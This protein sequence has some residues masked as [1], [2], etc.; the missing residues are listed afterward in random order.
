M[1][2]QCLHRH[3]QRQVAV[4][5]LLLLLSRGVSSQ[6]APHVCGAG[7]GPDEVMAGVQPAGPGVAPT[8]LCYWKSGAV[9][10]SAAPQARWEDR[11]GAIA[12]DGEG[13]A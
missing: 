10:G 9:Q 12:D 2:S 3:P 6:Q 8:P 11:W 1:T 13:V 7:P 5:V 4:G